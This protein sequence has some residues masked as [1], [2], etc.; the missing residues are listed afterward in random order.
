MASDAE[1]VAFEGHAAAAAAAPTMQTTDAAAPA[2]AGAAAAASVAQDVNLF[3]ILPFVHV[4][5]AGP[6][7]GRARQGQGNTITVRIDEGIVRHNF[8][9][10]LRSSQ[11]TP[12]VVA[13]ALQIMVE[14]PPEQQV[15]MMYDLIWYNQPLLNELVIALRRHTL[16]ERALAR[17]SAQRA[18]PRPYSGEGAGAGVGAAAAGP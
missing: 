8:H 14:G 5:P 12:L 9:R 3:A 17:M 15:Q 11:P 1:S 16:G 13:R 10:P 4:I 6:A 2:A 7:R 18:A